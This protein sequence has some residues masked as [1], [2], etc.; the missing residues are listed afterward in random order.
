M[1]DS[2]AEEVVETGLAGFSIAVWFLV[3]VFRQAAGKLKNWTETASGAMTVA[4]L[5]KVVSE[6]WYTAFSISICRS[7]Q[8]PR[9]FTC[10]AP[11]PPPARYRNR[12]AAAW[13]AGA[14]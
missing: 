7:R 12:S 2:I 6:S 4:A 11:S 10:S 1:F 8:T 3:L 14:A 13:F 9:C 5:L